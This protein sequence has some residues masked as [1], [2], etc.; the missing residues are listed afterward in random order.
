MTLS[1]AV[2]ELARVRSFLLRFK[3]CAITVANSVF[4]LPFVPVA[5]NPKYSS[6]GVNMTCSKNAF[7]KGAV[8]KEKCTI[9]FWLVYAV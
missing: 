1:F 8:W 6:S 5:V 2:V 3:V 4:H 9:V 7:V